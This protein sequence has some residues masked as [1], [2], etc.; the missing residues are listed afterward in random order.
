[1]AVNQ[2]GP[3][4]EQLVVASLTPTPPIRIQVLGQEID[5]RTLELNTMAKDLGHVTMYCFALPMYE[6]HAIH[7]VAVD[8]MNVSEGALVKHFKESNNI[9]NKIKKTVR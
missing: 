5:F 7:N 8:E 2:T 4:E 6:V 9:V 1:M 3:L